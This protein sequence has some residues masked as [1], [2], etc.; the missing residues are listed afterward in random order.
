MFSLWGEEDIYLAQNELN[1]LIDSTKK[2]KL[3]TNMH[4]VR[5]ETELPEASKSF[6]N[7]N[8]TRE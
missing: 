1:F 4:Q 8:S 6:Q 5:D 2:N 3:K 7:C